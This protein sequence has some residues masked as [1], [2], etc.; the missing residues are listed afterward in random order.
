MRDRI[1]EKDDRMSERL[2]YE[3]LAEIV[4]NHVD[5]LLLF[6][7][8]WSAELGSAEERWPAHSRGAGLV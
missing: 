6:A 7:R 8:Q 3:G 2:S 1:H 5:A 4:D